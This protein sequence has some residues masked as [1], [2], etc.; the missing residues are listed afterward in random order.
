MRWLWLVSVSC[1]LG[2]ESQFMFQRSRIWSYGLFQP[3]AK[4]RRYFLYLS[5]VPDEVRAGDIQMAFNAENA[6][7]NFQ[8]LSLY[9][10]FGRFLKFRMRNV[11]DEISF[12]MHAPVK[13]FT[14][15]TVRKYRRPKKELD[16]SPEWHALNTNVFESGSWIVEVSIPRDSV[17]EESDELLSELQ[18]NLPFMSAADD[19]KGLFNDASL[20]SSHQ[21]QPPQPLGEAFTRQFTVKFRKRRRE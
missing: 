5:K 20:R 17:V 14:I 1:A 4:T 7:G 2:E 10:R 16:H 6:E 13:P 12:R 8:T 15:P 9:I 3:F 11:V 21:A 18:A 19:A